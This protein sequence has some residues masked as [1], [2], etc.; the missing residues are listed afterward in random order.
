MNGKIKVMLTT[1]G[2]Y[3]FHQGGVGTWSDTIVKNV[4][5]IE[6]SV[7]SIIMNPFVTQK[8][9]LPSDVK[10]IK[11]PLWGTEEPGEHLENPFSEVF[12]SKERTTDNIIKEKFI[13][14]FS[15]MI[16]CI[17]YNNRNPV[18]SAGFI[19]NLY[20]YFQNYEYKQSFKSE[21]TWE[22]YKEIVMEYARANQKTV[23][24]PN[25]F[26][27]I[28]SLGWI[29]RFMNILNTS[30]PKVDVCHSSAAGFCGLP[31]V[32]SKLKNKSTYMLTEH[33]VYLREQYLSLAHR[34]YPSFLSSFL[35]KMIHFVTDLN[36]YYADQI[37]PVCNY[38]T[39]WEKELGVD[40]KKIKVIYNG[41]N[42]KI[43]SP[44]KNMGSSDEIKVV[45]VAR[46]DP[47]KDIETL[48]KAADIVVGSRK[49]VKFIVYG[50]VS[51]PVYY[52]KCVDLVKKLGLEEKFIFAGHTSDVPSAYTSGDIIALS[53]ISEAFP[54][55]VVEA[56]MSGKPVVATDVGGV[57]EAL[58]DAGILVSPRDHEEMAGAIIKLIDDP[59][60][61]ETLGQESRE[62]AVNYFNIDRM[63][64]NHMRSYILLSS[65]PLVP[66]H[67]F[68]N[69]NRR[70][71]LLLD[72]AKVLY[73]AGFYMES[74]EKM[75]DVIKFTP[76]RAVIPYLLSG[77]SS[78]Y[79]MLGDE[80]SARNEEEKALAF[81]NLMSNT[82]A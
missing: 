15:G 34:N 9:S 33:G 80:S 7:Y 55:S 72:M 69:Q 40:Q 2:T 19:L 46:I 36:Y 18:E 53:S 62:R 45:I 52:E 73:E 24:M 16:K 60:L 11:L 79:R 20:E 64:E 43:F 32:I 41:V 27:M 42:A 29:Y 30:I 68:R 50:S 3:P 54:Y 26:S 28:Q 70:I 51:V 8:F 63:I 82:S 48:I 10:L 1:E 12:L 56:M 38:N 66:E 47:L 44:K 22:T 39:R 17:L 74:I 75:R 31:C 77:I 78:A 49:K 5:D 14:D 4:K 13:Q 21:I 81:E 35:M 23:S 65:K 67:M 61:R 71:A 76:N 6:F 59:L 37:S 57:N 58:G 25:M